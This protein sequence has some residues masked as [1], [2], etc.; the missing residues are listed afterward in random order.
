MKKI[1]E[2]SRKK[3]PTKN[4]TQCRI[5]DVIGVMQ[6]FPHGISKRKVAEILGIPIST[7]ERSWNS[8]RHRCL[9]KKL[10]YGT[11]VLTSEKQKNLTDFSLGT[12]FGGAKVDLHALQLSFPI[13]SDSSRSEDWDAQNDMANWK[14]YVK[15]FDG[16]TVKKNLKTVQAWAWARSISGPEEIQQLAHSLM[17]NVAVRLYKMGVMVDVDHVRTVTKHM[18]IQKPELERIFPKGVSVSVDLGRDVAKI[19]EDDKP[20]PAKAWTDASPWR[21]IETNDADYAEKLLRMPEYVAQ[22][23]TAH[24]TFTK[25]LALYNDNI[26]MHLTAIQDIRDGIRQL[27]D[28]VKELKK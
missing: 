8:A 18:A 27:T 4:P 12:R 28:A 6:R 22:L 20:E 21:G 13:I 24:T 2:F 19:F 25:S 14:G 9:I 17:F 1:S 10:G 15:R 7:M 16:F 26:R 3:N 23:V 11:F 5:D